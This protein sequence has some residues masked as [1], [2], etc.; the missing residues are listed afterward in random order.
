MLSTSRSLDTS[1]SLLSP[2]PSLLLLDCGS[3]HTLAW[4]TESAKAEISARAPAYPSPPM[5][6]SPPLPPKDPRN[7]YDRSEGFGAY[8]TNSSQDVYTT[9]SGQPRPV[10]L[11]LQLPPP[12]RPPPPQYH[13]RIS[14]QYQPESNMEPPYGYQ[15]PEG[16]TV[17]A[18]LYSSREPP[19]VNKGQHLQPYGSTAAS[20][21]STS[22]QSVESGPNSIENQSMSSPKSQ[23]KTKGHVASACVPCKRAHLRCDAQ[24][25]CSRCMSNGKED[26][27]VDVQHKKRGRPRLRDDRDARFDPLRPPHS[28]DVSPRRPL[29]I[30]P[31]T[32][33][34]PPLFD[35]PYQ[36]H[37][38]FRQPE[39]STGNSFSARPGERA[40]SSDSNSYNTSL[41]ATPGS[42]EPVAY[43]TMA[44]EFVK[45][46]V[47]FW[48]AAGLPNMAGR[49]LGDVVLPAELEKV[50]QIQSH[51]NS[52][53]KRREPNYLPPILGTGSQS[54]Q[55]LGFTI[56]DFGRFPLNFHDHM[57]FVG[58]NGYARPM[59]IR[60]GLAKEGSFYFIVLL[61]NIPPR[62]P[63]I[64][65][66]AILPRAQ[67]NLPYKRPNPEILF[68]QR[69][70]F[71]PIRNRSSENFHTAS[72][73]A[74]PSNP[75]RPAGLV[76]QGSNQA[77]RQY[78]GAMERQPYTGR[79]Y[80]TT[81]QEA[82]GQN[83]TSLQQGFRLPPIR[84]RTERPTLR[85]PATWN[86]GERSSRVDIGVLIDKPGDP[87]RFRDERCP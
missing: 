77:G 43:L 3:D 82:A 37:P 60:A 66:T 54:I 20:T 69:P 1:S 44:L 71:D 16:R 46:S 79:S 70:P 51:F 2:Q 17:Q 50:S 73:A 21:S 15:G 10:D 7:F 48:D 86:R 28:Q 81:Q 36:R 14:V 34:G 38:S 61:L 6:G 62:Q 74:E 39:I 58:A 19:D 23:R 85:E 33:T 63:P 12:R 80:P 75:R 67:S 18:A 49:N 56:E 72:L 53:Q 32:G 78:E 8:S 9:N 31:S 40:S 29:S 42:S 5:S 25:P 22:Q 84:S 30:Y 41:S 57:A 45:G 83:Y 64:P 59:A 52:E 4:D 11:R 26:S 35:D 55:G 76:E 27:C 24:R 65:P 13:P 68:T 87:T 47:S